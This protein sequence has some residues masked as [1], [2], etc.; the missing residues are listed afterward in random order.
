MT[1]HPHTGAPGAN[2]V[3]ATPAA[4]PRL[5]ALFDLLT[6]LHGLDPASTD[7]LAGIT[8]ERLRQIDNGFT[9]AHDDQHHPRELSAATAV[10]AISAAPLPFAEI[11]GSDVGDDEWRE[12]LS[13]LWPWEA[14]SFKPGGPDED[15]I[16]SGALAVAA[17]A[18]LFRE[19]DEADHDAE[20][21]VS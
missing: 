1:A 3:R 2:D 9:P 11:L 6:T 13:I 7:A 20:V 14:E 5:A 15:L 10:Y 16:R 19:P 12:R 8:E 18:R 4:S 17:L 21:E